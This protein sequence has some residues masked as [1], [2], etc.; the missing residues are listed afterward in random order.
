MGTDLIVR[1]LQVSMAGK[2]ILQGLNLEIKAG[3][4][5]ALMGPNGSGKSTLSYAL[6]GHPEYRIEGGEVYLGGENLLEFDARER[7]QKGIFLAFQYPTTIPGVTLAN[8]LRRAV[9]AVRRARGGV[10]AAADNSGRKEILIPMREFRRD[11]TQK[12]KDLGA[13]CH[14]P[15]QRGHGRHGYSEACERSGIGG[16]LARISRRHR[17]GAGISAG[18]PAAIR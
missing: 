2:S 4:I 14:G 12:M 15:R 1:N 7:A 11:V 16:L 13:R 3:E 9:S 17:L 8:F 5:H 10:P 6:M 18:E